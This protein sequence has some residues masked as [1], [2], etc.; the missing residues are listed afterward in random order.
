MKTRLEGNNHFILFLNSLHPSDRRK[1]ISQL[2]GEYI[3]T[4]VEIFSNFLKRGLTTDP[5]IIVKVKPHSRI[6]KNLTL[7]KVPLYQKKKILQGKQGGALLSL[8]LPIAASL[9]TGLISG[10]K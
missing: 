3:N 6:V 1:I 4:I 2:S 7:R 10:R 8:L 9:I 5:N